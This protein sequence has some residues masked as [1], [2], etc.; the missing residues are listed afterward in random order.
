MDVS[1]E[2]LS[3]QDLRLLAA[4]YA[5]LSRDPATV[6][7]LRAWCQA[8]TM[9]LIGEIETRAETWQALV[10]GFD[11][12]GNVGEMVDPA[13]HDPMAEFR[14]LLDRDANADPDGPPDDQSPSSG[15]I[16]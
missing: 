15:G 9:G 1:T 8:L 4:N 16:R 11:E 12:N 5:W 6:P 7:R 3:D 2:G 10:D 13:T 14:A